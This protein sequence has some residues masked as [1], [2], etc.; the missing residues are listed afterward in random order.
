MVTE[1]AKNLRF[2]GFAPSE[3][4]PIRAARCLQ[5]EL[6]RSVGEHGVQPVDIPAKVRKTPRQVSTV[7]VVT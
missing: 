5:L 6:T 4:K 7:L 2:D 3:P 1:I